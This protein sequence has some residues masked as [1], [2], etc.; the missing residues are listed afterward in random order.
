MKRSYEL[1]QRAESQ[2]WTK[3]KIVEAAMELH[4]TKGLI[5]TSMSDI[6]ARAEVGKVTVYRHFPD[7]AALIGACSGLYFQRHPFPDLEAWR[8]IH[9]ASERLRRGLRDAYAYHRETEP[10]MARVLA[11]GRNHPVMAPYHA[12]WQRAAEAL[13]APWRVSGK[14]KALL[15]SALALALS[16]DT[17]RLLVRDQHL[18]DNQAIELMMR[19][20]CDCQPNSAG[21]GKRSVDKSRL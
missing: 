15:M 12:H 7:Q 13:A 14:R 2:G 11:E 6:A 21:R 1:K 20:T 5:A 16:F 10:M 4:Q 18:T 8:N 17:W 9:D 3:Q 19:L